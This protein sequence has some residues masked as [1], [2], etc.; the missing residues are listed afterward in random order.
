MRQRTQVTA[1]LPPAVPFPVIV[2]ILGPAQYAEEINRLA[3][4]HEIKGQIAV[5]PHVR[6]SL[7]L[8]D[9]AAWNDYYQVR[10]YELTL[11]KIDMADE[12]IVVGPD[13]Q[14]GE[15][16]QEEIAYAESLRKPVRRWDPT[17]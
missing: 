13:E 10:L 11:R 14:L 17:L 2:T 15:T 1:V 4:Q 6:P 9:A 7:D 16:L 8:V 3:V 5:V 12:V